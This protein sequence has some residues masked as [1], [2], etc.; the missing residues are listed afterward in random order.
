MTSKVKEKLLGLWTKIKGLNLF[1][2]SSDDPLTVRREQIMSR[3][4]L[5]ILII[6]CT[7]LFI[8]NIFTEQRKIYTV[9]HP[10]QTIYELLLSKYPDTIQCPCTRIAIPNQAFISVKVNYHQICFSKFISETFID[11][12]FA[13]RDENMYQGDFMRMSGSHFAALRTFC[14]LSQTI[15]SR[16]LANSQANLLVNEKLLSPVDFARDAAKKSQSFI[17]GAVAAFGSGVDKSLELTTSN[18]ALSV[19]SM[20]Y[21]LDVL[22]N[23]DVQV[24][25]S[26]FLNCSC[27]MNAYTCSEQA[28]FY[29]YNS[30]TN[31]FTLLSTVM[32]I[33]A[34]CLPLLSIMRSN[35]ACWYSADCYEK[36][37][38]KFIIDYNFTATF[39]K[40]QFN[41]VLVRSRF[42]NISR[43]H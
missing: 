16:S 23:G 30:S 28:G 24:N 15:F 40:Y 29:S 21:K 27:L 20:S 14:S 42:R 4:Y 3:L 12:L 41:S 2:S 17:I 22:S 26:G 8:Y 37:G 39:L 19:S 34:T 10:T 43:I 18:Q 35:L 5:L 9:E 31:V 36:V 13:F 38:Y 11:Q 7:C 32:G 6:S 1:N 33:Q 25:P